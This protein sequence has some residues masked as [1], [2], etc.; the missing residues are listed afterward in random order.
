MSS[1]SLS[2][3]V[4][5]FLSL[6]LF[7]TSCNSPAYERTECQFDTPTEL[8]IECGSLAVPENR[9]N[10]N[11]RML[12]L[13]VAIVKPFSPHPLPDP[14]LVLNGGPGNESLAGINFWLYVFSPILHDRALILLDTRGVGYSQPSLNCPEVENTWQ[15]NWSQN[16]SLQASDQNYVRALKACHDRLI[17]EGVDLSAYTTAENVADVRD[18]RRSLG[19][20][21]WNLYG[22]DYGSRLALEIM[23]QDP[24][25]VRSV[26]LD[27]AYPPQVNLYSSRANQLERSLTLL[28]EHCEAHADCER[29][30][31]GLKKKFY[32]LVD[33]LD[34]QPGI[35]RIYDP[36]A[37]KFHDLY[38][39]GDRWIWAVSQMF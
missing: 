32:G 33:G 23:R 34:A 22:G 6:S 36:S 1:K 31:P 8:D 20:S 9:A 18:L 13:Q 17:S 5:L 30:Y 12:H 11:S 26:I 14:V 25:G 27:S 7:L 15:Q 38:L 19:Y 28:F 39:N 16:L 10:Q 24:A 21:K 35:Y 2:F 37:S 29:S 3:V 4:A